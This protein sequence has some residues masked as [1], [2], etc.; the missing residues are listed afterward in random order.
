MAQKAKAL[1]VMKAA[2]DRGKIFN[3]PARKDKHFVKK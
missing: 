1:W 2:R 3:D